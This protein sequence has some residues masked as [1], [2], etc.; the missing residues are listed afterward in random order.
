MKEWLT[1]LSSSAGRFRSEDEILVSTM[2]GQTVW[3]VRWGAVAVKSERRDSV[4]ETTACL[5]QP[6]GPPP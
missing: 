5:L 6:Y 2:N 3:K 4:S 1:G